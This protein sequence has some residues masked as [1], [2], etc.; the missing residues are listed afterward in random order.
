MVKSSHC[1]V[2]TP[3]WH[4][5]AGFMW[6]STYILLVCIGLL[7]PFTWR[8]A[9]DSTFYT[10]AEIVGS[11]SKVFRFA[12]HAGPGWWDIDASKMFA[13]TIPYSPPQYDFDPTAWV[14]DVF[15][16]V[17]N[18][19]LNVRVCHTN[20]TTLERFR[21]NFPASTGQ[22]ITFCIYAELGCIEA[23]VTFKKLL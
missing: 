15:D 11:F 18:S 22:S 8:Q 7:S 16:D 19:W 12:G 6:S 3:G 9:L 4:P 20:C 2:Q 13:C 23:K 10:L 17:I 14:Q 1:P 5:V 21:K